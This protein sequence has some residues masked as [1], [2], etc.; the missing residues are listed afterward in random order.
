MF[1]PLDKVFTVLGYDHDTDD[2]KRWVSDS[3][4]G[5]RSAAVAAISAQRRVY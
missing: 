4:I 2:S 3:V 1:M 5:V